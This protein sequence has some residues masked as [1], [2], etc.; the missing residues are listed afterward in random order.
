MKAIVSVLF[1]FAIVFAAAGCETNPAT[2]KRQLSLISE[3]QEISL[4]RQAMP[5]VEKQVG[6]VYDNAEV[7]DY[8]NQIGQA[9]AAVSERPNLPWT[10]KV[11]NSDDVNA[12]SMPGG[13][14]YVNKGLLKQMENEA[15]LACVLGHE[16][17]HVTARHGVDQ[18]QKSLGMQVLLEAIGVGTGSPDAKAIAQVAAQLVMLKYSR[19]DEYMAD[20]LGVRYA[21]KANYN[22]DGIIQ[23][24]NIFLKLGG[25]SGGL[26]ELFSTHPD[27][28]KRIDNVKKILNEKYAGVTEDPN[29]NFNETE[30][31]I[32]VSAIQ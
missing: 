7:A 5:D 20:E 32:A 12:F 3:Q 24:F 30:Y 25:S 4:G 9:L 31:K 27:T 17:G 23:V 11:V 16:I 29:M 10:F 28:V 8:V 2:G 14:I 19:D 21:V 13:F 26:G 1:L 15:Q 18:L 22:P 6:G